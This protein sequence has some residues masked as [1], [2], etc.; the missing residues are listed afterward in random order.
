M[1][2]L[3]ELRYHYKVESLVAGRK[4]IWPYVL[5]LVFYYVWSYN[6]YDWH[7]GEYK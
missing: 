4:L 5:S 7:S 6:T 2:E 1:P 3:G